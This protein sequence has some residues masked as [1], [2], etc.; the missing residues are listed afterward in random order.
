MRGELRA[1]LQWREVD[2]QER[3]TYIVK[4]QPCEMLT[5]PDFPRAQAS[6]PRNL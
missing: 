5:R 1:M 3:C 4:D 2:F 6:L